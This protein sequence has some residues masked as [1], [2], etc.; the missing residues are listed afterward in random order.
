MLVAN[1]I[2]SQRL[3]FKS[4]SFLNIEALHT[5]VK[6][7]IGKGIEISR[8]IKVRQVEV[9]GSEGS[10]VGFPSLMPTD[11]SATNQYLTNA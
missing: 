3:N 5:H 8:D 6:R 4:T 9:R 1:E 11:V 10:G 7:I 2:E